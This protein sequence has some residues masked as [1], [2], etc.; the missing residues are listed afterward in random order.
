MVK[1]LNRPLLQMLCSYVEQETDWEHYLPLVMFAYHTTVHSSTKVSPFMLMF[2][3][4]SF[5]NFSEKDAFDPNSYEVQL[6]HKMAS[7]QDMVEV[8][9]VEA[10]SFQKAACDKH[11]VYPQ[12]KVNDHVWLSNPRCGKLDPRWEGGWTVSN[13]KG[14]ST[15]EICKGNTRKVVHVNRLQYRIGSQE[16][17]VPIEAQKPERVLWQPP[18]ID[19]SI[20]L[21]DDSAPGL[22]SDDNS[23]H[24]YPLREK[25]PPDWLRP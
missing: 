18:P 17:A 3:Q 1:R 16:T 13:V 14:E 6:R 10:A 5:N 21:A 4:A 20:V 22:A 23:T 12:F 7:L 8:N 19:H 9:F 24:R 11:A 2:G 25:R 15:V